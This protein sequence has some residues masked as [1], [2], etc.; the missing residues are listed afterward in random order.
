MWQESNGTFWSIAHKEMNHP[1]NHV[2]DLGSRFFPSESQDDC[3]LVRNPEQEDPARL[4]PGSRP[5]ETEII[6]F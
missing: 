6:M 3:S 4:W 2:S 5:I 1:N